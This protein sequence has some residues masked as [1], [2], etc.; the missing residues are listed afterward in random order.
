MGSLELPKSARR[1]TE[2]LSLRACMLVLFLWKGISPEAIAFEEFRQEEEGGVREA[3]E[4]DQQLCQI[5]VIKD[6][7]VC[8]GRCK[9]SLTCPCRRQGRLS[10]DVEGRLQT[11]GL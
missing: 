3:E 11:W 6:T 1:R 10:V 5:W 2:G 9:G 4:N 7:V 8:N